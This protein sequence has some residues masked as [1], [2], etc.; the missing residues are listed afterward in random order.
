MKLD[1]TSDTGSVGNVAELSDE[2]LEIAD[3][4]SR[5]TAAIAGELFV[6]FRSLP[7]KHERRSFSRYSSAEDV[8]YLDLCVTE[9]EIRSQSIQAQRE[10]LA[11]ELR[12]LAT[13]GLRS[14]AAPWSTGE[15]AIIGDALNNVLSSLGWSAE[16]DT[17]QVGGPKSDA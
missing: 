3:E 9:E 4:F 16:T 7:A 2:L 10:L 15:R 12:N 13:R 11:S 5:L 6:C 17:K 8:L 1:R 14:R